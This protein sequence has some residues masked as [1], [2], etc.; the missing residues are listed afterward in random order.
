MNLDALREVTK[1]NGWK[2]LADTLLTQQKPSQ[3][4]SAV[5]ETY[6]I[7]GGARMREQISDDRRLV[8]LLRHM[9]KPYTRS[10]ISLYRGENIE[11]WK[12]GRIGLAWTPKIETAQMFASGL[13]S[14]SSGGV[15]LHTVCAPNSVIAEPNYHS[16]YLGEDQYTIDPFSLGGIDVIEYQPPSPV[17]SRANEI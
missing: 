9:L 1:C 5:F 7:E 12:K 6:W 3:E 13:N 2:A 10:Q 4:A 8:A 17:L 14:V 11:R 15:V 16:R